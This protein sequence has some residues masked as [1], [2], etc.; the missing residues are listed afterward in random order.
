MNEEF[1]GPVLVMG[2]IIALLWRAM[3]IRHT[4]RMEM[5]SRGLTPTHLQAGVNRHRESLRAL[6]WGLLLVCAG[7]GFFI[8]FLIQHYITKDSDKHPAMMFTFTLIAGGIGLLVYYRIA[9]T[10]LSEGNGETG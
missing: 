6:K 3:Q 4:E 8:G 1:L 5:L 7:T 10:K 2:G 9:N